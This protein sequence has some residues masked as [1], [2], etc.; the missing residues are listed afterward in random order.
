MKP[1]TNANAKSFYSKMNRLH[2]QS[3]EKQRS[4]TQQQLRSIIRSAVK[5]IDGLGYQD[6][7]ARVIRDVLG[8][9]LQHGIPQ[10]Q[11]NH[12]G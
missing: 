4:N 6:K 8:D 1:E 5:Q 9:L 11:S 2:G 3:Q 7:Q 10:P 12:R